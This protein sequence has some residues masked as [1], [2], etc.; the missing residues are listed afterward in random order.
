LP[1]SEY[2]AYLIEIALNF[3]MA[4]RFPQLVA[5]NLMKSTAD[6]I[7]SLISSYTAIY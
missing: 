1:S 4:L 5:D 3:S 2:L 7:V 6:E